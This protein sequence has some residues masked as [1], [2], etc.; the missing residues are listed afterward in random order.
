MPPFTRQIL[1][2]DATESL[3]DVSAQLETQ[4]FWAQL[5]FPLLKFPDILHYMKD[6]L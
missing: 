2:L 4:I 5:A 3:T 6:S 1:V